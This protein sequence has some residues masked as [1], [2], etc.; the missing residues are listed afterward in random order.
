M[1]RTHFE[2]SIKDLFDDIE[3]IEDQTGSII[4]EYPDMIQPERI[5]FT[6]IAYHLR[7]AR[8]CTTDLIK[9]FPNTISD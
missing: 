3:E 6:L 8:K 9:K 5:K 4:K 1:N 7:Q 2:L